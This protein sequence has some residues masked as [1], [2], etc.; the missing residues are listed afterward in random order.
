M[1]RVISKGG[2]A[3]HHAWSA[4]SRGLY[5]CVDI[6]ILLEQNLFSFEN[7]FLNLAKKLLSA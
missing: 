1:Y 2:L 6:N 5:L 4:T 7:S 3:N